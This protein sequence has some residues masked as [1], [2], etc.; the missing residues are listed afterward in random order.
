M[1]NKE[2]RRYIIRKIQMRKKDKAYLMS[3]S[4]EEWELI[5]ATCKQLGISKASYFRLLV[6]RTRI[7]VLKR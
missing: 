4:K 6:K 3:F 7:E 5:E 1:G 2:Q